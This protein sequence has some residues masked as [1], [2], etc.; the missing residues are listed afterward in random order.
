MAKNRVISASGLGPVHSSLT[1]GTDTPEGLWTALYGR[2]PVMRLFHS[3]LAVSL[4]VVPA[5]LTLG[6]LTGAVLGLT[7]GAFE[8]PLW[9]LTLLTPVAR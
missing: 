5:A 7:K 1:P 4:L 6:I 2:S 9:I 8:N 3:F